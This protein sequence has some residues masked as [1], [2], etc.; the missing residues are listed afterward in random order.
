MFEN[1][2]FIFR[3]DL[4]II[5]NNGLNLLNEKCKNIYTIFIFTPEQVGSSNKYKS[6]NSVQFMIESLEDLA[7]EIRS[8]GGNL[9]TFYGKNDKVIADCIKA[10]DINVVCFNLDITPYAKKRDADIIQLCEKMKTYVMY[11]YDYYLHEPNT[12]LNGTGEPYQK[13]T[14]YYQSALKIKVQPPSGKRKIHFRTSSSHISNKITLDEA[15]NKFT[16]VNPDILVHGGRDNAIKQMKIAKKTQSHY[17]K[18]HNDLDKPTS[19]LSA[20]INFGNISIRE[21]YYEFKSNIEFIRQLYWGSFY[22]NVLYNYPQIIQKSLKPKYDK[23]KWHINE[24]WFD[25]WCNAKTNFP[26]VDACMT[27]LNVTGFLH[28]RGRLIVSSFLVKTMLI[29]YK[30]GER[31]FAQKLTDY[32]ISNNLN[33]WMWITGNG[34]SSQEYFKIFN[35]WTQG[36]E[37]DPDAIYIK[38]WLPMLKDVPAKAIHNWNKE[39]ENYKDTGYGKPILNYEEQR[40][41]ALAMYGKALK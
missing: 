37:H 19:R 28:G 15:L 8:Q 10:F 34:A 13:F 7:K 40:D 30:K 23:I 22:S 32:N 20:Y 27:E 39:W 18:T 14:P 12:I 24:G 3:R 26:I 6:D 1:G 11:D 31:Y 16:K 21:V 33:N 25:K 36:Y 17:S 5:D 35:P 9:Y 38:K 4:R 41:K 29:N 2:L